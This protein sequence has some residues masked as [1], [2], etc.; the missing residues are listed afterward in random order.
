M[1]LS[2]TST[3]RGNIA[4]FKGT[5]VLTKKGYTVRESRSTEFRE[6]K[7][8]NLFASG[9]RLGMSHAYVRIAAM[10]G[11]PDAVSLSNFL[12]KSIL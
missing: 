5:H 2:A 3:T 11:K 1:C 12:S 10:Q 8:V 7:V 6:I 9:E 4:W